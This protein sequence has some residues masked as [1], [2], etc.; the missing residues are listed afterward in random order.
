L[1]VCLFVC[2]FVRL[3]IS[4]P[5]IKLVASYF[6]GRFIGVLGREYPILVNVALP[7]SPE[8]D[9]ECSSW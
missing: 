6:A 2:L 1:F 4:L 3:Q 8:L 7:R 9:D 5:R